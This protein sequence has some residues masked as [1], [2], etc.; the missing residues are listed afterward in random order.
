MVGQRV[1]SDCRL[2]DLVEQ[3]GAVD[4]VIGTPVLDPH[5][6]FQQCGIGIDDEQSPIGSIVQ[7]NPVS[8]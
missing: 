6:N 2:G 3:S 7:G 4:V 1:G 8:G 5:Q